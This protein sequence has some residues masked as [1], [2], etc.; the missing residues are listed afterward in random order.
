MPFES[1][2]SISA[3]CVFASNQWSLMDNPAYRQ[4][5]KNWVSTQGPGRFWAPSVHQASTGQKNPHAGQNV[6][7]GCRL[8]QLSH[9]Q[10]HQTTNHQVVIFHRTLTFS[11]SQN[12]GG[13]LDNAFAYFWGSV[14]S[15][16]PFL[17]NVIG[18]TPLL[19]IASRFHF[20]SIT[21]DWP[22]VA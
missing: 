19:L 13:N 14:D 7:K 6:F 10:K 22:C 11:L 12:R 9:Q 5:K 2:E 21:C 20:P 4:T 3:S 17:R 18:T 8:E 1:F 16:G 15:C